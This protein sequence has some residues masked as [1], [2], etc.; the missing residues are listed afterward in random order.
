[1]SSLRNS[2]LYGGGEVSTEDNLH[3]IL[4]FSEIVNK[5]KNSSKPDKHLPQLDYLRNIDII[6]K[7][8]MCKLS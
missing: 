3:A 7:R 2:I 8:T 4:N 6:S 5:L 1:M